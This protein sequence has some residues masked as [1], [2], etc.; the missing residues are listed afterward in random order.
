MNKKTQARTEEMLRLTMEGKTGPEM[1]AA[2]R[3]SE[4]TLKNIFCKVI[5]AE[6]GVHTRLQLCVKLLREAESCGFQ[7]IYRCLRCARNVRDWRKH[8]S[9]CQGTAVAD[10][11]QKEEEP[12]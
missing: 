6:Y 4:Q 5:F 8:M 9:L 11:G 10:E 2:L 7:T 12:Q 1:A 3:I